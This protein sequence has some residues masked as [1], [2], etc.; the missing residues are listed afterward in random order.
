MLREEA[1]EG[2]IAVGGSW[3]PPLASKP[4]LFS[5]PWDT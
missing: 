2:D 3:K 5:N 1:E 4:A